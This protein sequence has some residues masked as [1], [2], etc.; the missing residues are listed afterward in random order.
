MKDFVISHLGIVRQSFLFPYC[1]ILHS[2]LWGLISIDT[3]WLKKKEKK[4]IHVWNP[5]SD[6]RAPFTLSWSSIS[7]FYYR[8]CL[9]F[10]KTSTTSQLRDKMVDNINTDRKRI[11]AG[12][13]AKRK[14]TVSVDFS[15][16][17]F[18]SLKGSMCVW[19]DCTCR[20]QDTA[21]CVKVSTFRSHGMADPANA[22]IPFLCVYLCWCVF[23]QMT[24]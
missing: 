23:S 7:V 2:S 14:L 9:S 12:R 4:E 1:T 18:N 3:E 16:S 21:L 20:W 5:F 13:G 10:P 17:I 8:Y 15:G 19:S 22:E 11:P 24:G 6:C